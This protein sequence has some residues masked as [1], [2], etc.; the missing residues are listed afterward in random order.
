M[1]RAGVRAVPVGGSAQAT[2]VR[3]QR[4]GE[5][6]ALLGEIVEER[7]QLGIGD[8]LRR[9]SEPSFAIHTDVDQVMQRVPFCS[10]CHGILQR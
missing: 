1:Q 9:C 3:Q 10:F 6:A 5:A 4:G 2:E 7:L 8:G